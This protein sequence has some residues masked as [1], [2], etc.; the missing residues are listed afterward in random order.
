M[1]AMHLAR[2]D[3]ARNM[4]RLLASGYWGTPVVAGH[5]ARRLVLTPSGHFRVASLFIGCTKG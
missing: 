1:S 3:P 5:E 4:S 2:I